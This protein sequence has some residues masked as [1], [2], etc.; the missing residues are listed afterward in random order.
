MRLSGCC[1]RC[2]FFDPHYK[3]GPAKIMK[4]EMTIVFLLASTIVALA[5][6]DGRI[7]NI[8]TEGPPT[9]EIELAFRM[10]RFQLQI[11]EPK[12]TR[13][14]VRLM[15]NTNELYKTWINV[16][17]SKIGN[18]SIF[19]IAFGPFN[20]PE[21]PNWRLY[22]GFRGMTSFN[23][24]TIPKPP[25]IAQSSPWSHSPGPILTEDGS[26][27][28]MSAYRNRERTPE[29]KMSLRLEVKIT[30]GGVVGIHDK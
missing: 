30:V 4:T 5:D 8:S 25:E 19:E 26:F 29:N 11:T 7:K 2:N 20:E 14:D 21:F 17:Q 27:Q 18:P 13:V 6:F 24:A 28:L 22:L 10:Q 3:V 23:N 12:M 9:P 16:Y 15:L 1:I